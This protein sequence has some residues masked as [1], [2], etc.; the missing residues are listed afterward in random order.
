M[1]Y[2]NMIMMTHARG[3]RAT[4][5]LFRPGRLWLLAALLPWAMAA[6]AQDSTRLSLAHDLELGLAHSKSLTLAQSKVDEA[7]AQYE[8][9]L[10]HRL[11]TIKASAMASEAFIPTR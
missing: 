5:S 8:Q 7:L 4:A 6:R 9:A 1:I 11:P 3:R 10:D 2:R